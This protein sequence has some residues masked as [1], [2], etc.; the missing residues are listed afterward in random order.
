MLG[1]PDNGGGLPAADR[2]RAQAVQPHRHEGGFRSRKESR[3][4]Q[5]SEERRR[6]GPGHGPLAG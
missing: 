2:Q 6:E 4:D 3:K 5:D 1:H